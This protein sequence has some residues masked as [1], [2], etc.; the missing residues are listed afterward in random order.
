MIAEVEMDSDPE[1]GFRRDHLGQHAIGRRQ[2][3]EPIRLVL[4]EAEVDHDHPPIFDE[5]RSALVGV[6]GTDFGLR[7][8]AWISRFT[9]AVRQAASYREGRGSSSP[10]TPPVHPARRRGL[11]TGVQGA[12][13]LRW[14]LAQVVQGRSP[15]ELLD[16][17]RRRHPVASGCSTTRWSRWR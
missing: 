14:K 11:G 13:N 4:T 3:D 8:A 15:V 2:P 1:L 9:D 5:L 16:T 17:Y 7:S 6:Y 12:V 10:A